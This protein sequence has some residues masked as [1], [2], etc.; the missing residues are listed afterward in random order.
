MQSWVAQRVLHILF[1]ASPNWALVTKKGQRRGV[2]KKDQES[3]VLA[4]AP[5]E[6]YNRNQELR[7]KAKP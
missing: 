6:R 3:E 4:G 2:D 7:K 1:I 5:L